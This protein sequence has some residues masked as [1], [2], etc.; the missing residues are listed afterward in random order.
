MPALSQPFLFQDLNPSQ[1]TGTSITYPGSGTTSTF[2]CVS[3]QYQGNGFFGSSSGVATT[4][5]T[6]TGNFIGTC[7]MQGTLATSPIDVSTTQTDWFDIVDTAVQYNQP[8]STITNY[9]NFVGNFVW[10]RAKVDIALGTLQVI[11][12][13]H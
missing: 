2:T 3:N 6:V 10:V 11:N 4:G 5:Y 9:V 1:T 8:G 12:Y 7:T 13:N